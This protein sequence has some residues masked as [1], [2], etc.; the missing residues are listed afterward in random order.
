MMDFGNN[1]SNGQGCQQLQ[2]I[3]NWTAWS[4]KIKII[5]RA[6]D[7]MSVIEGTS[8]TTEGEDRE[9]WKRKD[10]KAQGM[11]V[12]SISEKVMPQIVSCKTAKEIWDKLHTIYEQRGELSVHILQQKFFS[13]KFEE[14]ESVSQFLGRFE[15][16]LSKLKNLNAEVSQ[17]MA[18]TKITLSLP[19]QFQHFV[20]AW[21]SVPAEKRTMD[22]L[23]ARLLIE[24]QRATSKHGEE[25]SSA[26]VL[27][28]AGKCFQ[29]GKTGHLKKD[30]KSKNRG[31]NIHCNYCKKSNHKSKYCWFKN[32]KNNVNKSQS[33]AFS[34][35]MLS[36][37]FHSQLESSNSWVMDSGASEHMCHDISMFTK[38]KKLECPRPIVIGDGKVIQ[39]IGIG[40]IALEAYTGKQWIETTLNNVLHVPNLKM[41]LFSASSTADRGYIMTI[42]NKFCYFT[43]K[44]NRNVCAVAYRKN[45][46]FVMEFRFNKAENACVGKSSDSLSE[47]H[48]KMCH[49]DIEQVK[50]MLNKCDIDF[51]V[52]KQQEVTCEPCLLGKLHKKPFPSSVNRAER[53]GQCLHIDL[54]GTMET[55]S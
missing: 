44:G 50:N 2:G 45:N 40:M 16:L 5:L 55:V 1:M 37:L 22:E 17:T 53:P 11:L 28:S 32:K 24:E 38:Y 15:S 20:S 23:T 13:I 12:T 39:A 48:E 54:C 6:A 42:N 35:F 43:K 36:S 49:Q 10:A 33:N 3:E 4:F 52:S 7:L 14:N 29:C 8:P 21:E 19:S 26:L 27:K 51:S 30:C 34:V 9:K 47:W 41:N 31:N 25:E 46:L 18:I